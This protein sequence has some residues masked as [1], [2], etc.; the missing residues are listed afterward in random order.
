MS[1]DG[2]ADI[3][4]AEIY[5][6]RDAPTELI[7]AGG[8]E[9][10]AE[11]CLCGKLTQ[12]ATSKTSVNTVKVFQY[13]PGQAKLFVESV[14]TREQMGSVHEADSQDPLEEKL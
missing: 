13:M 5:L 6:H 9:L 1:L 4:F 2:S 11:N 8:G 3:P 10:T 14:T 7:F 12:N